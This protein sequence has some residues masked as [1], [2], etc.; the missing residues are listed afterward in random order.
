MGIA[1]LAVFVRS[2]YRVAELAQ[3]FS[4]S[5]ANEEVPFMIFEG[6][7]IAIATIA[8]TF[9]HPGLIFG[10]RWAEANFRL[11]GK[12]DSIGHEIEMKDRWGNA[13]M[14]SSSGASNEEGVIA[15]RG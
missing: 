7:M 10:T 4:G 1:T 8:L 3:G 2:V 14:P 9:F 12:D 11:N 5:I 13:D 15:S 6:T